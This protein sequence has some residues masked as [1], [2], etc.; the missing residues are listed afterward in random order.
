MRNEEWSVELPDGRTV[1]YTYK[2]MTET[3]AFI[4]AQV[5]GNAVVYM[6]NN[7]PAPMTNAQVEAEFAHDIAMR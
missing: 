3:L 7:I 1:R 4:T 2:E 5:Q 6:H